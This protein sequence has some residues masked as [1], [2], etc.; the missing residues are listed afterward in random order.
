MTW[1]L[2]LLPEAEDD[3]DRLPRR[4]QDRIVT[5]LAA[6]RDDPLHPG[7]RQLSGNLR[8][9]FRARAGDYRI[10]YCLDEAQGVIEVWAIGHRGRFYQVAERRMKS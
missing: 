4:E 7:T 2:E 10:G 3:F 1:E 5:Q 9:G 6:L 8:G